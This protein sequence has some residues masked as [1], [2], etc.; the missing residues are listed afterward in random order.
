MIARIHYM[1]SKFGKFDQLIPSSMLSG[2]VGHLKIMASFSTLA[3]VL[4]QL[5]VSNPLNARGARMGFAS[6]DES[7]K[8][9]AI[10]EGVNHWLI[11]WTVMIPL[12]TRAIRSG[13]LLSWARALGKFGGAI[14]FAGNLQGV[15]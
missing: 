6:V 11:S 3:L 9:A 5:F 7:H 14:L 2:E 10:T 1:K 8:E 13:V 4:A 12:L 15:T